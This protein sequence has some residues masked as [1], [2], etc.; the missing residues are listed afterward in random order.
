MGISSGLSV[1]MHLLSSCHMVRKATSWWSAS[2]NQSSYRC[3]MHTTSGQSTVTRYRAWTTWFVWRWNKERFDHIRTPTFAGRCYQ[4]DFPQLKLEDK[5]WVTHSLMGLIWY[6]QALPG[7]NCVF[8]SRILKLMSS[9][10]LTLPNVYALTYTSI[11]AKR[12]TSHAGVVR[13][14]SAP[15]SKPRRDS[16]QWILAGI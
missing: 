16:E 5:N 13:Q 10:C 1:V 8:C 15:G 11:S 2:S 6:L 12:S 14:S 3:R 9:L 7:D 4:C